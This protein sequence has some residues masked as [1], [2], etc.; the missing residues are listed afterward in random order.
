MGL[1]KEVNKEKGKWVG[2]WDNLS[3]YIHLMMKG[4]GPANLY[5]RNETL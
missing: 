2:R 4:D 3:N 5:G 1:I